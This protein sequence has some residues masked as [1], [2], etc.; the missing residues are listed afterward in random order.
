MMESQRTGKQRDFYLKKLMILYIKRGCPWC[1][2]AEQWLRG[3]NI[4]YT[5]VDV[6]T[7]ASAYATMRKVSGQSKAPVLVTGEGRVLA[8][9]G[10]EDLPGFLGPDDY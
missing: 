4:A 5:A 8:D 6:L 10:S 9:F 2:D 1:I 3:K 7:D